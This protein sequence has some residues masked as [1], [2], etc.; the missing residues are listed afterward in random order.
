MV[1]F[2]S[3]WSEETGGLFQFPL[4]RGDWWFI[5][6]P[7]GPRRLVVYF[8]SHWS[9]E[10]GGLFQFPLVRGDWWFISE[11]P[12]PESVSPQH[13]FSISLHV[14]FFIFPDVDIR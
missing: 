10:T 2:S 8:S 11:C 7:T 4:V 3:H 14:M 5:S 13:M 9:E 1:Y 6:V 12:S